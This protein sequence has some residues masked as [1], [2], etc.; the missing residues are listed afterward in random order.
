MKLFCVAEAAGENAP[1]L[2]LAR[3]LEIKVGRQSAG[4]QQPEKV[5]WYEV[6]VRVHLKVY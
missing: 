1:R 4:F 5:R 3:R 2:I 6:V